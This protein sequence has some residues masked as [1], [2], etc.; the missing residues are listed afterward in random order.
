MYAQNANPESVQNYRSSREISL[1]KGENFPNPITRFSDAKF[2]DFVAN[3]V[4]KNGFTD[5]TAIQA[6]VV[7][8]LF[9]LHHHEASY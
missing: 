4:E 7:N 2:P 5:P 3:F 9:F 6:Q 1:V 8:V